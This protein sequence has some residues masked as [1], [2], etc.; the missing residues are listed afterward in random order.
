MVLLKSGISRK[1]VFFVLSVFLLSILLIAVS[2]RYVISENAGLVRSRLMASSEELLLERTGAIMEKVKSANYRTPADFSAALKR[3]VAA[4][5]SILHILVF[6]RTADDDYYRVLDKVPLNAAFRVEA[7]VKSVVALEGENEYLKRGVYAAAVDPSV[8]ASGAFTWR[9]V[10]HPYSLNR[11]NL[12]VAFMA[13]AGRTASALADYDRS[14]SGIK[15]NVIIINI[16]AAL[17]VFLAVGLFIQNY[18]LFLKN[19]AGY[20]GRA[21]RGDLAVNISAPD[22]DEMQELAESFNGLIEEMRV[23]KERERAV[24]EKAAADKIAGDKAVEER[25]PEE[26]SRE[27]NAAGEETAEETAAVEKD[28]VD[29][30]FRMGVQKLKDGNL[31]DAVHVFRALQMIRPESFGSYFNLGVAYAKM[32]SYDAS[33][34]MFDRALELNPAHELARGYVEK[35]KQLKERYDPGP[36]QHNVQ[37]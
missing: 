34:E 13:S 18:S 33:L 32:R 4:E 27:E 16:A 30:M 1:F 23:L 15:R 20:F 35:V 22:G 2:F 6:A 21:S 5:P 24:S 37:A 31:E 36:G 12:V 25:A 14:I 26:K 11:R 17:L 29:D 7:E 8:Y 9:N 28:P 19:L 10:Y 3:A